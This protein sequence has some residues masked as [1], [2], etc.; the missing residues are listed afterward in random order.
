MKI[1]LN[2]RIYLFIS[3]I[4]L[5]LNGLLSLFRP[6]R[7]PERFAIIAF[8][9][10]AIAVAIAALEEFFS[11]RPNNAKKLKSLFRRWKK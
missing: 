4:S 2:Y 1:I 3:L 6:S 7:D 9:S 11:S 8:I 10:F 5:F